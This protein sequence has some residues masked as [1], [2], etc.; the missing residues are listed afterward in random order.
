M[1]YVKLGCRVLSVPFSWCYSSFTLQQRNDGTWPSECTNE[2]LNPALLS[3]LSDQLSTK[4][5]NVKA[6]IHSSAHASFWSHEWT[7]H[8][9]CSGMTQHDY[10]QTALNLLLPTPSIVKD[11]YGSE[12]NR[13]ELSEE[14]FA[15]AVM[16]CS[17][18][19]HLSEA[20]VCFQ[21]TMGDG[22][23]VGV[24]GRVSCP[25]TI[26]NEDSCGDG[27]IK[28]ASFDDYGRVST[29]AER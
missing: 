25:Q 2:P 12:V 20:R 28:I 22:E 3:K 15:D 26:L 17:K 8:G 24:G 11:H 19:G 4:W 14:A 27:V 1:V 9:T 18:D 6:D 21:K 7:K 29:A 23:G 13:S 16:L 5:P 10:F